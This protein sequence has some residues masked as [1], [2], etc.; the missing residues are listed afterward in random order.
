MMSCDAEM[1]V[2]QNS[3]VFVL[4]IF[5]PWPKGGSKNGKYRF[6][7]IFPHSSRFTKKR[8]SG[9]LEMRRQLIGSFPDISDCIFGFALPPLPPDN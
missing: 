4:R 3:L 5:V 1:N 9:T 6:Y 7:A 8:A 2:V